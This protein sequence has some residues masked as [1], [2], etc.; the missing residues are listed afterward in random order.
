MGEM[1]FLAFFFRQPDIDA[2]TL[3]VAEQCRMSK[4]M[5]FQLL[6]TWLCPLLLKRE[7]HGVD[8]RCLFCYPIQKV[9]QAVTKVEFFCQCD[10]VSAFAHAE[11]IP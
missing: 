6:E 8:V 10:D 1:E 11:I 4:V 2:T 9:G 3:Q 5:H 7:G